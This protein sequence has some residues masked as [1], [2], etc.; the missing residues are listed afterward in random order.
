MLC[1]YWMVN[2][3]FDFD[4]SLLNGFGWRTILLRCLFCSFPVP[5]FVLHSYFLREHGFV[6]KQA[7]SMRF[8][9]FHDPFSTFFTGTTNPNTRKVLQNQR[10]PKYEKINKT[11]MSCHGNIITCK[12]ADI[13]STSYLEGC[14]LEKWIVYWSNGFSGRSNT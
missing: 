3:Y 8:K 12:T 10:L 9:V 14:K 1:M 2:K 5:L 6:T 7:N 4:W 11:T 13:I